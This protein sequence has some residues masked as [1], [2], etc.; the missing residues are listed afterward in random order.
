MMFKFDFETWMTPF[1]VYILFTE[2]ITETASAKGFP[3]N[4]DCMT[5]LNVSLLNVAERSFI[6]LSHASASIAISLLRK[7]S[8]V[9]SPRSSLFAILSRLLIESATLLIHSSSSAYIDMTIFDGDPTW[10]KFI[11]LGFD[12][13]KVEKSSS[14]TVA[15]TGGDTISITNSFPKGKFFINGN[16]LLILVLSV[17][18]SLTWQK[19]FWLFIW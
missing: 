18:T 8:L 12:F 10:V 1:L 7:M 2:F 16:V 9:L 3:P 5:S 4:R 6:W 15:M 14:N 17:V 19:A 11:K 13:L